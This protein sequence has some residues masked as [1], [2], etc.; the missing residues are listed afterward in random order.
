MKRPSRLDYIYSVGRIRALERFLIQRAIFEEAAETPEFSA[1]L[2]LIYD[3]GRYPEALVKARD[4]AELD[5]VL[6]GEEETLKHEMTTL[7]LEKEVLEAYLYDTRPE[8]ALAAASASRY[9]FLRDHLRRRI[10]LGNIKVFIRARYQGLTP[11]KLGA[12]LLDGGFIRKKELSS[13]YSLSSVEIGEVPDASPY[14]ELWTK[15]V[16]A[17]SERETFVPLERG[18]DDFLMNDLRR[19][20]QIIF[21]PEPVFAYGQA[22]KRELDLVRLVGIGKM[23]F[24]PAE[25]LQERISETYV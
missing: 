20:R 9:P 24:I 7:I 23:N 15:A 4:S 13:R 11:E 12:G 16:E 8:R 6:S 19:A 21:G 1:A 14:R 17:L 5:A 25:L 22:K 2:K 10:D 18:I 3:S